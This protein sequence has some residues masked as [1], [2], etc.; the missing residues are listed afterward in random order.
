MWKI[1]SHDFRHFRGNLRLPDSMLSAVM[2]TAVDGRSTCIPVRTRGGKIRLPINTAV[3]ANLR[4]DY[5]HSTQFP[6]SGR[7]RLFVLG[8][9]VTQFGCAASLTVVVLE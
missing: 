3:Y 4:V 5:S 1:D 8:L 2:C 6:S 7:R 9:L